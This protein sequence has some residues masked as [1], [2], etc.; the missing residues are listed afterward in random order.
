MHEI[1][2][3]TNIIIITIIIV[4]VV[5]IIVVVVLLL[6]LL[7]LYLYIFLSSSKLTKS[8]L[9]EHELKEE[10]EDQ[11]H[12]EGSPERFLMR[13]NKTERNFSRESSWVLPAT[14]DVSTR[15]RKRKKK[16]KER[17][18]KGALLVAPFY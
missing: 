9:K 6:P 14:W 1:G 10:K 17:K 16:K 2:Q 8:T 15:L 18:E 13:R 7:L 3:V 4:V 12:T 5:V 11:K